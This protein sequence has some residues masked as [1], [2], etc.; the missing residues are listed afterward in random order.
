MQKVTSLALAL[1]IAACPLFANNGKDGSKSKTSDK[2]TITKEAD[3]TFALN[4]NSVEP[5]FVKVKILSDANQLLHEKTISFKHSVKVPFNMAELEEGNYTFALEGPVVQ[6]QQKVFLSKMH[7]EDVA[8]FIQELG[9]NQVKLTVYHD[10]IPVSVS[11][12]DSNGNKYFDKSLKLEN[13]FVQVFDLSDVKDKNMTVV[14]RGE[15][16]TIS[17]VL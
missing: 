11:L 10:N 14:V 3:D 15:K 8:A 7:E 4:I 17:K 5:G 9:D 16:T 1:L 12:V 2:F 6:G 13:N